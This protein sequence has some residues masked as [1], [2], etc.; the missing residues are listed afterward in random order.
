MNASLFAMEGVASV[1]HGLAPISALAC[2][3]LFGI[4]NKMSA[5]LPPSFIV[6]SGAIVVHILLD[7]PLSITAVTNGLGLLMLLWFITPREY[8]TE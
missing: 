3:L 2:G 1:G 7:V 8:F 5:H 6:I 4:G